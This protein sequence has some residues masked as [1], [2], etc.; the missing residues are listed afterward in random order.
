MSKCN[1][2]AFYKTK[3]IEIQEDNTAVPYCKFYNQKITSGLANKCGDKLDF[4]GHE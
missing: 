3:F 1:N 4:R 2:C